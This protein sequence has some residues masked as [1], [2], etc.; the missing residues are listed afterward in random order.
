MTG[1]TRMEEI[2]PDYPCAR[3]DRHD[4]TCVDYK[5]CSNY[6]RW[7][8]RRLRNYRMYVQRL[9][10]EQERRKN[11]ERFVVYRSW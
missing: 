1:E 8:R 2:Y 6:R 7:L 5:T 3:C 11:A 9:R 10:E 4:I